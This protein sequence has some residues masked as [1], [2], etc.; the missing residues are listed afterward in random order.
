MSHP[1]SGDLLFYSNG[2]VVF[3]ASHNLMLNGDKINPGLYRDYYC[4]ETFSQWYPIQGTLLSM[5]DAYHPNK[6]YFLHTPLQWPELGNPFC[7]R[8]MFSYI[9]MN[10]NGGL[11]EVVKKNEIYY[12]SEQEF[13][14]GYTS[15]IRHTNGKDWRVIHPEDESNQFLTFLIDSLGPRLVSRQEIGIPI[16]R[17]GASKFS[18]DGRTLGLFSDLVGYFQYD[19]DRETGVLSNPKH[20]VLQESGGGGGLA[21]SPSSEFVYLFY[22][23]KIFQ[24]ETNSEDLNDEV[25]LV[26]N[27]ILYSDGQSSSFSHAQL[28]PDC[29]IYITHRGGVGYLGVI[30]NPDEKGKACNL[31]QRGLDL[32][33]FHDILSIPN[34]PPF[35]VDEEIKC[36]DTMVGLFPTVMRKKESYFVFYPNPVEDIL[37]VLPRAD[38]RYTIMDASS[39]TI[40]EGVLEADIEKVLDITGI[41]SGVYYINIIVGEAKVQS[42]KM[43][44]I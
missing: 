11:G 17:R 6:Y 42:E 13:H 36:D 22:E 33:Y 28:G 27:I 15:V 14:R 31:E 29:K 38:G 2:C 3:D 8:L 4:D 20:I 40:R 16:M 43:V 34:F 1:I 32:A 44:K 37:K 23:D 7:D 24:L 18:S 12:Q 39:A 26:D 41:P 30:N 25:V 35:R 19:F 10:K 9:D 5:E 21:Y